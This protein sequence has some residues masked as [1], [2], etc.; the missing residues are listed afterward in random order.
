MLALLPV[1]ALL[2]RVLV[3]CP[4]TGRALAGAGLDYGRYLALG[5]AVFSA[6]YAL[7]MVL[8]LFIVPAV[9]F[10]G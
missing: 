1:L 3:V 6:L 8:S 2:F 5:A 7:I 10:Y 4:P 9:H